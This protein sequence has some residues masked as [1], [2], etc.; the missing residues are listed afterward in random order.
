MRQKKLWMLA[1]VMTSLLTIACGGDKEKELRLQADKTMEA[2]HK[3][4]DYQAMMTN[5]DSLEKAG[6]LSPTKANYWRGYACDR[7]KQK[8][9]AEQY[10]KASMEAGEKTQDKED[11]IM[12]AKAASHLA[13]LLSIRGDYEETLKLAQPAVELLEEQK[14]DTTSDYVNL[15]IYIGCCQAVTGKAVEESRHGFYR[16]YSKHLEN[17]KKKHTDASYKDAIAGL[18]NVALYCVKAKKYEEA[19]YYTRYFGE[20]L[21]EYELRPDVNQDYID[22]QLGRYDIYKAQALKGLG[23]DEEAAET[24]EAF[25]ETDFSQTPEGLSLAKDYLEKDL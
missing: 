22:R 7:L 2:T 3:A 19:L 17:I 18:I 14:C 15:L 25:E 24:F 4:K 9:Q 16:A 5:A 13:N 11:Y 10:W 21:G 23:R 20:L 12:Y 1:F 6:L 8:E